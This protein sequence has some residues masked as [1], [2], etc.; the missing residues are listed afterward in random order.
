MLTATPVFTNNPSQTIHL[1]IIRENQCVP[2][3]MYLA[4]GKIWNSS[5]ATMDQR[6]S[7][8]SILDPGRTVYTLVSMFNVMM[9]LFAGISVL[10][11]LPNRVY[12]SML[13]IEVCKNP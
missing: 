7:Q 11:V 5:L 10:W 8:F 9:D 13:G 12:V 1:I 4:V 6:V 3:M 2:Q